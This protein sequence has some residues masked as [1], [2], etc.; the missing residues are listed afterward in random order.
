[1]ED[2][3]LQIGMTAFIEENYE[4]A[5]DQFSKSIEKNADNSEALLF[6]GCSYLKLGYYD[7]A[8]SDFNQTEIL[9][10]EFYHLLV[11]RSQAHFFNM[12]FKQSHADLSKLKSMTN[13]NDYQLKQIKSL[14]DN[15]VI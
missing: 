13:L 9:S 15:L 10:G 12:D 7:K 3:L 6:R 8:V 4:T 1:M 2:N 14:E 11:N 5:I